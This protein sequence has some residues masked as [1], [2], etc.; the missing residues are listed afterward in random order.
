M[1]E[2][3]L[4]G[5][6][7]DFAIELKSSKKPKKFYLRLWIQN[8]PWGAFKRASDLDFSI[9]AFK[10]ITKRKEEMNPSIF[11]GMSALE[12][13][14]YT[15]VN[16]EDEDDIDRLEE[17]IP[18]F[19]LAFFGKQFTDTQSEYLILCKDG[20][21]WFIW[22]NDYDKPLYDAKISF[23]QFSKVFHEYLEYCLQN[24]LIEGDS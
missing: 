21:L 20:F 4:F 7:S 3:I 19:K 9:S 6:K 22:K 18:L 16:H 10:K 2:T 12:I 14:N 11:A 15:K 13:N 5:N 8:L 23:D 1:Q 24:K 17:L